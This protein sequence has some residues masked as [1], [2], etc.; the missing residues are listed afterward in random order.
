MCF[1]KKKTTTA[2][3]QA[4]EESAAAI[5]DQQAAATQDIRSAKTSDILAEAPLTEREIR[6]GKRGGTGRRTLLISG[7][8]GAGFLSRFAQ[9]GS[10]LWG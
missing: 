1:G 8:G 2:Q 4:A 5:A 3:T 6:M 9:D 10:R 7:A